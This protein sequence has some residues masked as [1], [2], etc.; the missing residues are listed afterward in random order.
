MFGHYARAG[1]I[2]LGAAVLDMLL[3]AFGDELLA[4]ADCSLPPTGVQPV[5]ICTYGQYVIDYFLFGVT[6][7]L[8]AMLLM[9]GWIE[10]QAPGL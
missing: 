6:L 5:Q 7:G 3:K 1:L 8:I 4:I 2:W 10:N 9:R